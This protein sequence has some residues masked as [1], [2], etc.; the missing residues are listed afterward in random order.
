MKIAYKY[1]ATILMSLALANSWF[2][3]QHSCR[4]AEQTPVNL[5][6]RIR[7]LGAEDPA[8]LPIDQA[9]RFSSSVLTEATGAELTVTSMTKVTSRTNGSFSE[10]RQNLALEATEPQLMDFLR[11]IAATN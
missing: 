1:S 2:C 11:N 7:V 5:A 6:D 4:G 10:L 8:L 3:F 9:P